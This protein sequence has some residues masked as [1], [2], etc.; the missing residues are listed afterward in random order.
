M[1]EQR[2]AVITPDMI[3]LELKRILNDDLDEEKKKREIGA[4]AKRVASDEIHQAL[5]TMIENGDEPVDLTINLVNSIGM[6]ELDQRLWTPQT[7]VSMILMETGA[8][9]HRRSKLVK[10]D[11]GSSDGAAWYSEVRSEHLGTYLDE[12]VRKFIYLVELAADLSDDDDFCER[13]TDVIML[14][15]VEFLQEGKGKKHPLLK[16][17]EDMAEEHDECDWLYELLEERVS[18][19]DRFRRVDWFVDLDSD[20]D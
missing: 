17:L 3:V 6:T 13:M 10:P 1:K 18:E 8:V 20:E 16:V 19:D 12:E 15:F 14:R 11:E 2:L 5:V 9:S 7:L 4:L